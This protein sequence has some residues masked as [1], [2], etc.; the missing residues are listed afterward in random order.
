MKSR[1]F[2]GNH[3]VDLQIAVGHGARAYQIINWQKNN[4]CCLGTYRAVAYR[5]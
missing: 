4:K 5:F 3:F 1:A 2:P